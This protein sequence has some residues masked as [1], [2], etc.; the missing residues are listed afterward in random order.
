M[1][2]T[3]FPREFKEGFLWGGAT[4]ANQVEGGWN[5]DEKGLTTAEVVRKAENRTELTFNEVTK[6]SIKDAIADSTDTLYPKR[7]GVDFYHNYREDIRLFA[8]MG[9]KAYRMSIAWA[10]IFPNGD[11][12]EPNEAGLAFYDRVFDEL[13][14]YNIEPVVTLSH[15]EMPLALTVKQNGWVSRKTITSFTRYTEVVFKRYR[16]KVK[17]WLTF[18]EINAGTFGFMGTGAVD[19]ALSEDEK[20]Q[21][22]YQALHHQFIASALAVT[23]GHTINPE[24]K[25]GSMLA[26]MQTYPLTPN[27]VDVRAAQENDNLNLFFTDVQVRGEYP[28][29]MNRYLSEHQVKLVMEPDDE[30]IIKMGT[31]DFISFSYY[32][33]TVTSANNAGDKSVGN[34]LNG[35][36]NPYLETSE[37]G[38]QVD[39]VGLRISLNEM[40]NRYHVP[41]FIVENGLGAADQLE[42]DGSVHD[43]YRINYLR[44][45]ITQMKEAVK[46]GVDLMGYTMWGCIDLISASTSEMS[47]R[48]GFIYVDQDDD[49]H[50]SLKRYKKDSFDWYQHVIDTNGREM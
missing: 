7:R 17:Y 18:N 20:L 11:E 28:E 3:N 2:Q 26:R 12:L 35:E 29:F 27:P 38:W 25:I 36:K 34:M 8:E 21:L 41:L 24:F 48:Y 30:K 45:H 16:N 49:G 31:V 23:Q 13:A 33:S 10:R 32:M 22:R 5:I 39:P 37:W 19:S 9:F 50:G 47:K 46:D 43:E 4:A 1:Y 40:W 42:A 6:E 14:K 44:E 15:Y